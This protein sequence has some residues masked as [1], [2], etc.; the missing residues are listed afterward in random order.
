MYVFIDLFI[1]SLSCYFFLG[2]SRRTWPR[3]S[4]RNS[5]ASGECN[6]S[7]VDGV[8]WEILIESVTILI[9]TFSKILGVILSKILYTNRENTLWEKNKFLHYVSTYPATLSRPCSNLVWTFFKNIS[10]ITILYSNLKWL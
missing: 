3:W 2:S 8:T 1:T 10:S 7:R 5:R 6:I 9:C 4:T